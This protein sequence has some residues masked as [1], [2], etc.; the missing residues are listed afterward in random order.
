[1]ALV[2]AGQQLGGTSGVEFLVAAHGLHPAAK[3]I[4]R[5]ERGDYTAANPAVW[6]MTLGQLEEVHQDGSRLPVAVFRTGQVLVDPLTPSWP[7]CSG[8]ASTP[9]PAAMTWPSSVPARPG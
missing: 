1:M 8:P 4:L 2:L 7:S 9:R 5:L 6:A 3:R